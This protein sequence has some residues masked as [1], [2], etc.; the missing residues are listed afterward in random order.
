MGNVLAATQ[1]FNSNLTPSGDALEKKFED[2]TLSNP[3]PFEEIHRKCKDV[4]PMTFEGARLMVNKGLSNHFQISHTLS[5]GNMNSGYRF[6]ATYVGN[7][8]YSPIEAFPVFLGD[9]DINGNLNAQILHQPSSNL[10]Y[11]FVSQIQNNKMVANQFTADYKG[12]NYTASLTLSPNMAQNI[13]ASHNILSSITSGIIVAQYLQNVTP[14]I[15]LGTE[16]M[17]HR[18]PESNGAMMISPFG[19]AM[20]AG[21]PTHNAIMSVGARYT[22][23]NYVASGSLG[24]AGIKATYWQLISPIFQVG[25]EVETNPTFGESLATL[26]Y[27][28]NIGSVASQYPNPSHNM[29][30]QPS[31]FRAYIDSNATL[32]A[33]IEKRLTP[34]PLTL[35][36]SG[37]LNH[38]KNMSKFGIGVMLG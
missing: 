28:V 1:P 21:M 6:G 15:A 9:M 19:G 31:T 7:K 5:I 34:L 30:S 23:S 25:A 16:L 2:I 18:N 33:T 26:A 24:S 20:G 11:K 8:Q 10:R 22:G 32:G 17:Y 27:Q 3:G 36:L 37:S 13:F 14:S 29:N 4:Y 38:A 35:S 12:K